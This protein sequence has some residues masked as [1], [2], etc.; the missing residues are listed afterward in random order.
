MTIKR[1]LFLSNILMIAIPAV[2][3]VLALAA[4]AAS[5]HLRGC[6]QRRIPAAEPA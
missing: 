1:R 5:A 2:L 3:S 4:G 6:V